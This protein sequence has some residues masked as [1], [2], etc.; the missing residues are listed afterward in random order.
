MKLEHGRTEVKKNLFCKRSDC[1]SLP[2]FQRCGLDVAL[3]LRVTQSYHA[4]IIPRRRA[5]MAVNIFRSLQKCRI[6]PLNCQISPCSCLLGN[7]AFLSSFLSILRLT[8]YSNSATLKI[9][10]EHAG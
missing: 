1:P 4:Q 9:T 8:S 3:E 2:A 5:E 10:I 7:A 6:D